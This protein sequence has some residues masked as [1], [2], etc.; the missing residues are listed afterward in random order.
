MTAKDRESEF[1]ERAAPASVPAGWNRREFK[2]IPASMDA[3]WTR[4]NSDSWLYA[5]QLDDRHANAQGVIHGG[6][7]MTFV[8]H[9][10]SLLVWEACGRAKCSTIQLDSHFLHPV[11]P[12]AFVEL[13]GRILRQGHRTAFARAVLRV[14][15]TDVLEATGVWSISSSRSPANP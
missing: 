14:G 6:V 1:R 2:G 15:D 13:D 11:R 12:P 7:L 8:D 5:V 10:L 9:A 4:R 3:L